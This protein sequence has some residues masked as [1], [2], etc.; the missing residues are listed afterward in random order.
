MYDRNIRT[1]LK[2]RLI[3]YHDAEP[4]T[5]ILDEL[6]VC[7]GTSRVDIAVVNGLLTGYEIKGDFDTLTRLPLQSVAYGRVFDKVTIVAG[8]LHVE[9]VMEAVPDWWGIEV[10]TGDSSGME[11]TTVREGELNHN[12]DPYALSQLLWRDEVLETLCERGLDKGVKSKPREILWKRLADSVSL[13]EI[14]ELVRMRLKM[15]TD[16]RLAG[17]ND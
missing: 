17:P 7:K 5:L 15:R 8:S 11:F 6:G 1:A 9:K 16:W 2:K 14:G 10:V 12:V 4:N 13:D 3:L